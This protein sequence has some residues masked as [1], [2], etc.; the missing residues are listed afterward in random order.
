[1]CVCVRAC[2]CVSGGVSR[3]SYV[4][5]HS[6]IRLFVESFELNKHAFPIYTLFLDYSVFANKLLL[7]MCVIC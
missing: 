2:V 3:C 5:M 1:M 7:L 4:F 6:C